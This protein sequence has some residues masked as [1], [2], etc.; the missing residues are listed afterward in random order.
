MSAS[1]YL[2]TPLYPQHIDLGAQMV[3][4]GGW[5]MPVQYPTGILQEHLA[6]RRGAGLFDVSHM[7]EFLVEGPNA[8]ELVQKVTSNDALKLTVGK[9]QYSC[10]PNEKEVLYVLVTNLL[11]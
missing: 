10:M 5:E 11:V 2:R 4:F 1:E 7:G 9:A 3:P 8:L 6:T